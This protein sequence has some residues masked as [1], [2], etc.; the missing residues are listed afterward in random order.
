[1]NGKRPRI[2]GD[3]K[4]ADYVKSPS[5]RHIRDPHQLQKLAR[6]IVQAVDQAGAVWSKWERA[7]EDVI[8]VAA[9]CWIPAED[10]RAH[11]NCLPG[12]SLTLTDVRQ[13]LRAIWEEPWETYPNEGLKDGCLALYAAEK[14]Q[15][16]EFIAIVGALREH[17]DLEE[18]H[19]RRERDEAYRAAKEESQL[20]RRQRFYSGADVGWTSIDNSDALYCRRNGRPFR[21]S[22]S[23]DKR[24]KL[25]RIAKQEDEGDL[26]GV[27][28][29][30]T[31][32]NKALAKIAYEPDI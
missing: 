15:G 7:R 31:D 9:Q 20:K 28:G 17:I 30:R 2:Y 27:Y 1:M 4:L 18:E 6:E 21:T 13:R 22:L 32:A 23:K 11:M 8:K 12:P 14:Q 3:S 10:L 16:T 5:L 25:Y 29:N 26:L 24:W 19:L